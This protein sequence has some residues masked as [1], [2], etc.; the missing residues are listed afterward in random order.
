MYMHPQAI[1][2]DESSSEEAFFSEAIGQQTMAMNIPLIGIPYNGAQKLVWMTKLDSASLSGEDWLNGLL[3]THPTNTQ[4]SVEE[5]QYGYS[6]PCF[7]RSIR[8]PNSVAQ[9]AQCC[10]LYLVSRSSSHN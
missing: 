10:R 1:I 2:V 5:A 3:Y 7:S 9:V 4:C 6:H 8:L